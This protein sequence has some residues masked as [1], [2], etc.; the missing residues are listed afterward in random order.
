[1]LRSMY[2]GV[3]GLKVHQTKMDVIGNNIANVNT[4]AYKSGSISFQ[5]MF[6]QTVSSS[7]EPTE[8][9]LGGTNPQQI[10]LGVS[11][12]AI[13]NSF[14][15]GSIQLTSNPFDFAID[16]DGFF[17]ISDGAGTQYTR[18]GNFTVDVAGNL[19]TSGGSLVQG[20]NYDLATGEVD[21]TKELEGVNLS[22]ISI[23]SQSTTEI[24]MTGNLDSDL[25]P[26]KVS[27]DFSVSDELGGLHTITLEMTRDA[28]VVDQVNYTVSIDGGEAI[29]TLAGLFTLDEDGNVDATTVS[30]IEF[31]DIQL[32]IGITGNIDANAKISA[33]KMEAIDTTD[34]QG[35]IVNHNLTIY[36]SLGVNHTLTISMEKISSN[37]FNYTVSFDG[38]ALD[39]A[40]GGSFQFNADGSL[41][42]T[43]KNNII[44]SSDT[45]GNGAE[46]I[47]ITSDNISFDDDEFTQYSN[48]TSISM[49]QDGYT[50]GELLSYSVD[51]SGQAIGTF[52]N[53]KQIHI[54]TIAVAT[55]IN[56]SG[57]EKVGD[58]QYIETW[59]SGEADI[60]IAGTN[61][62]GTISTMSLEMSNVDLSSE[63]TEMIV[64]QR[65][66]QA[67][68]RIIT[69]SDEI[70]E[71]LVNLKR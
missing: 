49:E 60:G 30:D 71:E 66:F 10:G 8:G 33:E 70:L 31:T 27:K 48:D 46:E 56:S 26:N 2:A 53:G 42:T 43:T 20:W 9:G 37:N 23:A 55:F 29:D 12:G 4:T 24:T 16:G 58:S 40:M 47:I 34:L 17:I 22:D 45:I 28:D 38:E 25:T 35:E 18:A 21:T 39:E 14:E 41:K 36:D 7:S 19:V 11:I 59:N 62:R 61:D 3:S 64:A 63:F 13:T 51:Q 65:G 5:E 1:M 68:S 69:T 44:I 15:Q 50:A 57:L 52:S 67:N 32:G 54:A 6:S